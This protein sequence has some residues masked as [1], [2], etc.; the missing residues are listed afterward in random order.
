ME[1]KRSH[2]RVTL[3]VLS[4]AGLAYAVLTS[5]IVPALPTIQDDLRASETGVT[6]VLTGYLLS[7]SVATAI[8]GRLGDMLGKE[9]VLDLDARRLRRGHAARR[10]LALAHRADRRPGDPGRR[11]R[12]LPALVRDHPRRV[13]ARAVPGSIGFVSAILGIGGAVGI[14]LGGLVV[15]HL[16]WEWLFWLTLPIAIVPARRHLAVHPGVARPCRP[17]GSTGSPPR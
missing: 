4:V 14:V 9:H 2:P 5:A 8:L 16:G 13:P 7:A 1:V 15:E 10:A 12:H 3:V 17:A 11:R 6:F